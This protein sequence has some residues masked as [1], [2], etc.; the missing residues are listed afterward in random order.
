MRDWVKNAGVET[1]SIASGALFGILEDALRSSFR[2]KGSSGF[3]HFTDDAEETVV[4]EF[5]RFGQPM[6]ERMEI[7]APRLRGQGRPAP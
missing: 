6:L 4:D 1:R 2:I 5:S 3:D 7:P